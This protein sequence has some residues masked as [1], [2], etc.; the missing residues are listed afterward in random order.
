MPDVLNV[1]GHRLGSAEIESALVAHPAVAESAVIGV[2]HDVKG[3][4][5]FAY[6][7]L[8]LGAE[9]GNEHDLVVELKMHV[10]DHVGAFAR[11]DHIV[12][13]PA[14]PKT[15]SGKIMRRL[16]RKIASQEY[17]LS[18]LGDI[19]TLAD[20]GVVEDLIEKVKQMYANEGGKA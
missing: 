17:D 11:P 2:P 9:N 4:A 6:V 8:K 15:R 18:K 3:N 7:S 19:T 20:S 5:I 1:S 16:L 10:R 13:T 14:L 12:I